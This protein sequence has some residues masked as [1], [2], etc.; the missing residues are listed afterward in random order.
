MHPP[1]D[2]LIDRKRLKAH[3][4]AWRLVALVAI[5]GSVALLSFRAHH[6]GGALGG[7]Y[8]AQV[9]IDGI[10]GDSDDR[11]KLLK[12]VR[13][14]GHA[15]A[16][17]VRMD[18]PGGTAVAGEVLELQLRQVAAKKPVVI[19][20]R[21]LCASACYMAALGGDEIFAR[22]G[23]LT[24]SIGVLL[25]SVEISRLADK[26]GITPITIK[27]GKYKDVPSLTDP[28]TPDERA[29]V[30]TVVMDAYDRF[31]GLIVDRRKLPEATV[32]RLADGRVYTGHQ[33]VGLHLIDAIGGDDEAL[34]WLAKNRKINAKLELKEVKPP[35]KKSSLL[36]IVGEWTGGKIFG[37]ATTGLDG[38]VSIW[39]P[40]AQ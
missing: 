22:D 17:L 40:L 20:M 6:G 5:F 16:L 19:V 15:K 9:D 34:A 39:H 21:T 27:S 13:D 12:Q 26:L 30:A 33:A 7:D 29:V 37:D 14:D 38:L 18:S 10:M 23:T 36:D 28:L 31:V 3:L 8:I 24:G 25:Q 4:S 11:D 32:R 1:G 35:K 2:L